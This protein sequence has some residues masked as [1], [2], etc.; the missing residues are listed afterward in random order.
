MS[1]GTPESKVG[2][3]G[4][5]VHPAPGWPVPPPGW[6]P[7]PGWQPDPQWETPTGW[8]WVRRTPRFWL[9]PICIAVCVVALVAL[10]VL[11][12]LAERSGSSLDPTD[13]VNFNEYILIN[14]TPSTEFVHL[15]ADMDCSRL[16]P[17]LGWTRVGTDSTTTV[18]VAWGS[19]VVAP[20]VVARSA[21]LAGQRGC[22]LIAAPK[23]VTRVTQILLSSAGTCAS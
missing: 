4:W 7:A 14:D 6:R 8:R 3:P 12:A 22:V 17:N 1:W 10:F 18:T 15:C 13:P 19:H 20:Y 23:H 21:S 2:K 16:D 11:E 9:A 5:V